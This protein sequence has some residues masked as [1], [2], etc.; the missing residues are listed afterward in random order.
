MERRYRE[1]RVEIKE[2]VHD[3]VEEKKE[4]RKAIEGFLCSG[5]VRVQANLTENKGLV[6]NHGRRARALN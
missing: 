4:W 2:K 3:E 6:Q 5:R 1:R